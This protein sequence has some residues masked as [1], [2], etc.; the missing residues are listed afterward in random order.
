MN[1]TCTAAVR[2]CRLTRRQLLV[3]SALFGAVA[4]VSGGPVRAATANG[5]VLNGSHWGV[6]YAK[7]EGGR[8]TSI[9]P[10]EKDPHPIAALAGV[11]DIVYGPSRIRYPMVRR[12]WLEK[13]PGAMPET[14]GKG[15]F[16]RVSWDQALD[17]VAKEIR[18]VQ[19]DDGPWAIFGGSYGWR[20]AGR[21]N[22]QTM[23]KRLL[24]LTGGYVDSSEDYSKA[25]IEKIMPYVIG[26]IDADGPQSTYPTLLE[27]NQLL[28]F[29]GCSPLNNNNIANTITDHKVWDFFD[30]LA[31]AGR[32]AIFIDPVRTDACKKLNGEWIA[33][34]P[35]TDTAMMIGIA[36][37]L[38]VENRHDRKF[39]ADYTRG[40]DQFEAYLLGK[41]D[42]VAKT[43]E[44]ASEICGIP[45]ATLRD[46]AHRFVA[47]RT[48]LIG[49]WAMQRQHHG[50][51]TPW[52]LATLAA[53][54]GQIGL[55]GGGFIQRYH[56]DSGG[57]PASVAPAP[58]GAMSIGERAKD[59]KPWPAERGAQVIP[60]ARIVDMLLSPGGN[61]EYNG[62]TFRYP[63]MKLTY[64]VGGN[65]F[66]HHQ[67]RNRQVAAWRK[68][69]T[70]IVQDFQWTASARMADIV[71]PAATSAEHNDIERV[72]PA[73][74]VAILAMKQAIEP[75]FEARSDY[76]IFVA[77]AK[78]LGVETAFTTGKTEMDWV[79]TIYE[80][81]AAQAKAKGVA[82]PTFDAFWNGTGL[83]EFEVAE[84]T[85]KWTKFAD[86]RADP[87]LNALPTP[88]GKIEI[89]STA[90]ERMKYDDCPPHPTWLEPLERLGGKGVKYPLHVNSAHP[91]SRL[92]SQLCGSDV[93][94]KL[95]A[96]AG[97]EP[98]LINPADAAARGIVSGDVV[99]LHNDRGQCLAGA[100][101]TDDIRPGVVRLNEG[102]WYD[103]Q[104]A[105]SPNTLCKY[106]DVN[107][108]TPDI[109]T[110]RLTQ[111]TSACTTMAEVEKYLGTPPAVS[112]FT[113]PAAAM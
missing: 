46:L 85:R 2:P 58:S 111:G 52:M 31:K 51:Q 45:A 11:Q 96:V 50:E 109:G 22:P 38:L 94:R 63:D 26:S 76:D 37:T 4:G 48:V 80:S 110:S 28:V 92:H 30:D 49:G 91:E 21:L 29:W 42:G 97:R 102:G 61:Y 55:P 44:W 101:V 89:F 87:L 68:F 20:S 79:R 24:N 7:V 1:E 14:R 67:D 35:G 25:A 95:Y 12:A 83:V 70:F 18:R 34:R 10:W 72:G 13:G 71:L 65:P 69:E 5:E 16:V 108:L 36:H 47:N 106:G 23:L 43:A 15:D 66:H 100:V 54:I 103:P 88:S 3:S 113:A 57:T 81:T 74:G 32:K 73:S 104:D 17:L 112:V 56:L 105:G 60:C 77:L 39:L 40:F 6:Y 62:R 19:T 86:F 90:I 9:R 41:P 99:R 33:P 64:W 8:F 53:M 75:V 82:M 93:V 78:R 107:V 98:C 27:S 59:A 84:A